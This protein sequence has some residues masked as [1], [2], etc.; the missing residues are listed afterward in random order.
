MS[1]VGT[2]LGFLDVHVFEFTGLKDFAAFGALHEFEVVLAGYDLDAGMLAGASVFLLF[3]RRRRR[4]SA[5]KP[6]ARFARWSEDVILPEIGGI[7][8]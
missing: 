5:H 8:A 7:L 6:V 1:G 4:E 2:Q 3:G